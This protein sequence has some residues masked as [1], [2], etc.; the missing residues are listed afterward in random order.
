MKKEKLYKIL[1]RYYDS[2]YKWKDYKK[3]SEKI[4]NI[5]KQYKKTKGKKLLDVACGTGNHITYLKKHYK[6]I[7]TD[8]NKE[9]LEEARKK[10]PDIKFKRANMVYLKF[11]K[12]FDI[13]IC[14]FSSIGYV[15]TYK[16]LEKTISSM[17][18]NLK[19]GGVLIIE[20]WLTKESHEIGKS[21]ITFVDKPDIKITRMTINSIK[22]NLSLLNFHFLIASR[23]GI[24]YLNDKHELG[25]FEKERFLK[26]MKDCDLK[27]KYIKNGFI[28]NRGL[29]IGIKK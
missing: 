23:S 10:F 1:A 12:Q 3:E 13:I 2:I 28:P 19:P 8:L 16:N 26:I 14:L 15:K 24:I 6:I 5:I 29:Y 27:A 20:P 18:K 21:H 9:M 25:L 11:K 22:G 4:H 7:G 17:S